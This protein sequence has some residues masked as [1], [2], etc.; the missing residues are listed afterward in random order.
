MNLTSR[1]LV[2]VLAA[3]PLSLAAGSAFAADPCGKFDFA[4]AA[5]FSCKIEVKGGC[6]AQCTPLS[7]EAGCTG[8][9]TATATMSCTGTCGTQCVASCDPTK[10]DCYAGCHAECDE[11]VKQQCVASHPND[12]CV[13]QAV[14]QCDIHCNA[15]CDV[16][17]DTNCAEHCQTCCNG[18]CTT[19]ANFDCDYSCFAELKG[20]CDVQCSEP[21]GALFCN[22][23]YVHASDIDACITYLA[24]KGVT[25]DVSA[26]GSVTCD[27]NGCDGEGSAAAGI[28]SV[29]NPGI[30][31]AA[32]GGASLAVLGL[33]LGLGARRRR[34]SDKKAS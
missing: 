13:T 16:A 8:G 17:T 14:A 33:A 7:F 15:Q 9:C 32:A 22:G 23:Q 27:L 29:S 26:R 12:D 24:D 6:S 25:V 11:P 2:A 28:C 5:S 21:D 1:V 30:E 10:L 20:G 31:S 34:R 4:D 18:G 19:Q 3:L